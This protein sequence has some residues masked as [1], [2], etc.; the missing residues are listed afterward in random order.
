MT[1]TMII[2]IMRSKKIKCEEIEEQFHFLSFEK[3]VKKVLEIELALRLIRFILRSFRVP[4]VF[5]NFMF[6]KFIVAPF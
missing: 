1:T 6:L 2:I 4:N 5:E 3:L